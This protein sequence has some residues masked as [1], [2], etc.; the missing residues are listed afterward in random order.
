MAIE[1]EVVTTALVLRLR[2]QEPNAADAALVA[3]IIEELHALLGLSTLEGVTSKASSIAHA[4]WL[5]SYRSSYNGAGSGAP[6]TNSGAQLLAP[7]IAYREGPILLRERTIQ[8][9]TYRLFVYD[10]P[11]KGYW[12]INKIVPL[13]ERALTEP[14]LQVATGALIANVAVSSVSG[15]TTD[16]AVSLA[17]RYLTVSMDTSWL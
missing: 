10:E 3:P 11:G 17:T 14:P 16:T 5:A 15:A 13:V 4:R 8:I 1:V 6:A 9:P 12:R 2:G 7:F